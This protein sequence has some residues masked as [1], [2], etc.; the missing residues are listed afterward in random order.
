MPP[1]STLE[2]VSDYEDHQVKISENYCEQTLLTKGYISLKLYA[3]FKKKNKRTFS[4]EE[5]A[6]EKKNYLK[7]DAS[8]NPEKE[9]IPSERIDI[10]AYYQTILDKYLKVNQE[11]LKYRVWKALK[12]NVEKE[13][14]RRD[15]V[16]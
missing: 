15:Y 16:N 3:S 13:N 10:L 11:L 9:R 8:P 14:I 4:K 2:T 1:T 5:I 6:E 12:A 7:V